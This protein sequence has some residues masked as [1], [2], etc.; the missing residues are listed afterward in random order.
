ME[1]NRE[2]ILD[3]FAA[4]RLDEPERKLATEG[5]GYFAMETGIYSECS[6][7]LWSGE[8]VMLPG[9]E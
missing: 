4:R 3:T 1:D 5:M 8:K 6:Y 2:R 9:A 7:E